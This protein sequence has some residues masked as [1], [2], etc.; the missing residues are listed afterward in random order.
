MILTGANLEN[1]ARAILGDDWV[2]K[3]A[4]RAGCSRHT[5]M[6]RRDEDKVPV[7]WRQILVDAIDEHFADLGDI[8]SQLVEVW[9][10]AA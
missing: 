8:R 9:D 3:L 6:R 2:S 10:D 1:M 7:A 5:V 4:K